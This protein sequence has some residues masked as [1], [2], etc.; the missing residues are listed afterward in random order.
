[1]PATLVSMTWYETASAGKFS[2]CEKVEQPSLTYLCNNTLLA[3]LISVEARYNEG[4]RDWHNLF[5]TTDEVSLY[6]F[7][8]YWGRESVPYIE[9]FAL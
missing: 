7:Y 5:A 1:M 4:P 3:Q 6:I 2:C 9:N 8:Y